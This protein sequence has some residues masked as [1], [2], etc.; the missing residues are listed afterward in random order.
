MD[1]IM[2]FMIVDKSCNYLEGRQK[3]EEINPREDKI[4]FINPS[5]ETKNHVTLLKKRRQDQIQNEAKLIQ[6]IYLG[7][8]FLFIF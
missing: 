6:Y 5:S 7:K 4:M 3:G 2:I 1:K 8:C